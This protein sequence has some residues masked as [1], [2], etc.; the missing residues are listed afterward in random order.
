LNTLYEA[1]NEGNRLTKAEAP[2]CKPA[3]AVK[4]KVV[5]RFFEFTEHLLGLL[6]SQ[7]FALYGAEEKYFQLIQSMLPIDTLNQQDTSHTSEG[8][9]A[10]YIPGPVN[11][12]EK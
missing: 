3:A 12:I 6:Q 11:R 5:V 7:E 9:T 2:R 10:C 8:K 1:R 4:M